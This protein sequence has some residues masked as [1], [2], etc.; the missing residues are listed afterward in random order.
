MKHLIDTQSVIW[1][2]DQDQLLSPTA[3]AVITNP[4]NDLLLSAA[5]V[6]EIAIKVGLKKLTL[7]LPYR[8]WMAKAIADLGLSILPITVD[9]ADVQAGLPHHHRDPFDRLIVAQ[10]AVEG[11][12][13]ISADPQL[14]AYGITRIW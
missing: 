12:Q 6:W 5:S 11:I 7:S 4:A 8:Q 9:Y 1:Y 13:V 10:A 14:D 3:H 2:V